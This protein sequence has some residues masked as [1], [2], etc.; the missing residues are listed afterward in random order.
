MVDE[1]KRGHVTWVAGPDAL[2]GPGPDTGCRRVGFQRIVSFF[3]WWRDND[4]YSGGKLGSR[5]GVVNPFLRPTLLLNRSGRRA[6]TRDG[7]PSA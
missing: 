7:C 1:M 5:P 6:V 4:G 2:A 3:R